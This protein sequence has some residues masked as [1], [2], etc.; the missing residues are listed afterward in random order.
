VLERVVHC[1]CEEDLALYMIWLCNVLA[2]GPASSVQSLLTGAA[3]HHGRWTSETTAWRGGAGPPPPG[4]YTCIADYAAPLATV[5]RVSC[6]LTAVHLTY[7]CYYMSRRQRLLALRLV[8]LLSVAKQCSYAIIDGAGSS[9][10]ALTLTF[11]FA[12]NVVY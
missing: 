8:I 6:I 3:F 1:C 7:A 4:K 2:G 10:M 5:S 9:T 11:V 12:G